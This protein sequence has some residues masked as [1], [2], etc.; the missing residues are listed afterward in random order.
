MRVRTNLSHDNQ[1]FHV[2]V[3]FFFKFLH[4]QTYSHVLPYIC[5]VTCTLNIYTTFNTILHVWPYHINRFTF[6]NQYIKHLFTTQYLQNLKRDVEEYIPLEETNVDQVKILLTGQVKAGKSSF[7]NTIIS[8]FKG[9]ISSQAPSGSTGKSLTTK[10]IN[11]VAKV[12]NN[13]CE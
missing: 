4:F 10:V 2:N 8:I 5:N 6:Y 3:S 1:I 12:L 9:A 13:V 11:I 7:I